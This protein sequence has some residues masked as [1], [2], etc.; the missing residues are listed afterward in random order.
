MPN[1]ANPPSF[2]FFWGERFLLLCK[3]TET[4]F[5]L[6]LAQWLLLNFTEY[7]CPSNSS[8]SSYLIPFFH[9]LCLVYS[10]R[11]K[12]IFFAPR[13]KLSCFQFVCKN[14]DHLHLHHLRHERESR[15][16]GKSF[17]SIEGYA[18]SGRGKTA[19][20]VCGGR[21]Q[22]RTTLTRIQKPKP[23]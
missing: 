15:I 10:V 19:R 4:P 2:L 18:I 3:N 22:T 23:S 6:C 17:D 7:H 8:D 5:I 21:K 13:T 1:C 9:S 11:K 20:Y 12:F 16:I 14:F